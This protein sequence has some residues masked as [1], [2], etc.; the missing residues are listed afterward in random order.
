MGYPETVGSYSIKMPPIPRFLAGT[1]TGDTT[2]STTRTLYFDRGAK[3]LHAE[4]VCPR[5][6]VPENTDY[7]ADFTFTGYDAVAHSSWFRSVNA[8]WTCSAHTM[9]FDEHGYFASNGITVS[10][11]ITGAVMQG[12][13]RVA[14]TYSNGAY[15]FINNCD[16][17]GRKLF[18]PQ[19]DHI[20]F[21]NMDFTTDWFTATNAGQY[22]FGPVSSGHRLEVTTFNSNTIAFERCASPMVYYKARLANGDTSFDGHGATYSFT[23]NDQFTS[24]SD[25]RLGSLVDR[26]CATWK[27]VQVDS[28]VTFDTGCASVITMENCSFMLSGDTSHVTQIALDSCDVRAGGKWLT[29]TR[30]S[31]SN[32]NWG[33][34]CELSDTSK[35]TRALAQQLSFDHCVLSMGANYIWTNNLSMSNC[36]SNAHVY[37]VPYSDSTNFRLNG[38]FIGNRFIGGALVE[39]RPKDMSAEWEVRD[40]IASLVFTDN[41]FEQDDSRGIVMPFVTQEFDW[42]KPF[43]SAS[44]ATQGGCEYSGNTGKCPAE[45]PSRLFLASAMTGS[46]S[47]GGDYLHYLPPATYNQRVWNLNPQVN[48]SP[49]LMGIQFEPGSDS[50]NR[51]NGRDA[52]AHYGTMLHS[53]RVVQ[54]DEMNDQFSCVHSWEGIDGWDDDLEVFYF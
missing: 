14:T 35:S 25:C 20:K 33:A 42:Q 53:V 40:V 37:L 10:P 7:V 17:Q 11:T 21:S 13:T 46:L 34:I 38:S 8:W 22:D 19:S 28:T 39:C 18:S 51:I 2:Y 26:K 49:G 47:W 3:F 24:I 1:Y 41:R 50:W 12:N 23:T 32:S 29:S 9:V 45:E 52:A 36:T 15:L 43:L 48:W 6:I 44:S 31:V 54:T 27:N 5:A 4:F 30:I 16:I